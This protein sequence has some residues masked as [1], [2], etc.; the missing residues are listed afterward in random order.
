M[1]LTIEQAIKNIDQVCANA[2]LNRESHAILVKSIQLI[3]NTIKELQE[4][5][6]KEITK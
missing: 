5:K 3:Q 4:L 2:N 6:K 1:E